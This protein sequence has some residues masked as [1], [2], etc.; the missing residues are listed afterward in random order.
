MSSKS[1]VF[2]F[3]GGQKPHIR[4]LHVTC[5]AHFQTQMRFSSQK[6]CVKIWLGFV[7]PFKSY[8]LNFPGDQK[9]PMGGGGMCGLQCPFLNLAELIQSKVVCEN[10]VEPFKS[11]RGNKH[12]SGEG[13]ETP[14]RGGY[15]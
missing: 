13:A 7:E 10:L 2:E 12:F 5:D 1:L 14:I 9:P 6:S 3:S 4:G 11:Y 15:I 8:H